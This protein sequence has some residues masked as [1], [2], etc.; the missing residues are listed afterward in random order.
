MSPLLNTAAGRGNEQSLQHGE[1]IVI[2]SAPLDGSLQCIGRDE[3]DFVGVCSSPCPVPGKISK[4][5]FHAM[6]G[7]VQACLPC[8]SLRE[9][10]TSGHYRISPY[11]DTAG[12]VLLIMPPFYIV[13][14]SRMPLQH[15]QRG[16]QHRH[17]CNDSSSPSLGFI[18]PEMQHSSASS[19]AFH[20]STDPS[21]YCTASGQAMQH[22]AA[23]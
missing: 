16:L 13:P 9:G 21:F 12:S 14:L 7:L 5:D 17:P 18:S 1:D 20:P 3:G 8:L 4:G 19:R 22:S 15:K 6:P 2:C 11:L 10:E 23:F